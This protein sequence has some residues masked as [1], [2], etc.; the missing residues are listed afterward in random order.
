MS[1]YKVCSCG[2]FYADHYKVNEENLTKKKIARLDGEEHLVDVFGDIRDI[3]YCKHIGKEW[4]NKSKAELNS[5]TYTNKCAKC[6]SKIR[7]VNPTNHLGQIIFVQV[8]KSI[9]KH[10]KMIECKAWNCQHRHC[11]EQRKKT[12]RLVAN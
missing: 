2:F 10:G 12:H 8:C 5:K 9:E 4:I 6:L 7:L 1:N 11:E 3:C